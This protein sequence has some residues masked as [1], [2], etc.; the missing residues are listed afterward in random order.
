MLS[1]ESAKKALEPAEVDVIVDVGWCGRERAYVKRKGKENGA[2]QQT[3]E[4]MEWCLEG[5]AT[6]DDQRKSRRGDS[7]LAEK[8]VTA[9]A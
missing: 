3:P 5:D 9:F 8:R 4:K 2:D 6:S 7:E 1:R